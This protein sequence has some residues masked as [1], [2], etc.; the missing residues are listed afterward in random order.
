VIPELIAEFIAELFANL[1]AEEYRSVRCVKKF[2]AR[3]VVHTLE[4]PGVDLI[5]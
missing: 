1:I 5:G 4:R 3:I 2:N